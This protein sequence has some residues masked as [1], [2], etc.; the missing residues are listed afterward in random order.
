MLLIPTVLLAV[1]AMLLQR[2]RILLHNNAI[3]STAQCV[4]SAWGNGVDNLRC[5]KCM[6]LPGF[7]HASTRVGIQFGR[8]RGPT[9]TRSND[10]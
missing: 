1:L 10:G 4:L 2:R 8:W 5:S 3:E 7:G 9:A 6:L